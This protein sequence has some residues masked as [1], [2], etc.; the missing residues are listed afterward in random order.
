MNFLHSQSLVNTEFQQLQIFFLLKNCGILLVPGKE[1]TPD[2]KTDQLEY[3]AVKCDFQRRKKGT[4]GNYPLI[5]EKSASADKVDFSVEG[6]GFLKAVTPE[7]TTRQEFEK[8]LNDYLKRNA[9]PYMKQMV[10]TLKAYRGKWEDMIVRVIGELGLDDF[11]ENCSIEMGIDEVKKWLL[12]WI[13]VKT[14]VRESV[15]VITILISPKCGFLS[16]EVMEL[17]LKE[18]L[19]D[20]SS[21]L[22]ET[23]GR[24]FSTESIIDGELKKKSVYDNEKADYYH[25]RAADLRDIAYKAGKAVAESE[26]LKNELNAIEVLNIITL[27]WERKKKNAV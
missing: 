21:R 17:L 27:V 12:D 2:N 16:D 9:M 11:T 26:Q 20:E 15:P 4:M 23:F 8:A 14:E 3:T 25:N 10:N 1:K 24:S 7:N 22:Y 13:F 6:C 5:I 18:Y 19:A